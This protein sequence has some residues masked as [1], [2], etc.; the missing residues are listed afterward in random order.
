MITVNEMIKILEN[1]RNKNEGNTELIFCTS[2]YPNKNNAYTTGYSG[3]SVSKQFGHV[4][5]FLID[6][7]ENIGD[8]NDR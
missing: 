8:K 1:F 4:V 6:L 5:L 7:K 3:L 2:L